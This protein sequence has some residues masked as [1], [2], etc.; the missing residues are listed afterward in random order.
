MEEQNN[1]HINIIPQNANKIIV[2]ATEIIKKF[3]S[4]HDRE[5]F[6]RENSKRI[7]LIFRFLF[8]EGIRV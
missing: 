6:C 1:N 3:R 4:Y 5:S 8:S 7:Y 2:K